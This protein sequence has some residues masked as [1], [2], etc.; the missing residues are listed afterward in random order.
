MRCIAGGHP[1]YKTGH[2]HAGYLAVAS[3]QQQPAAQREP[4]DIWTRTVVRDLICVHL[5]PRRPRWPGAKRGFPDLLRSAMLV[6][7]NYSNSLATSAT[8]Q[9]EARPSSTRRHGAT[10]VPAPQVIYYLQGCC[11]VAGNK[12]YSN[13][14]CLI[15]IRLTSHLSI[16]S[17]LS[18]LIQMRRSIFHMGV[19]PCGI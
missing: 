10:T 3:T 13:L 12:L 2:M 16:L 1:Q 17:L 9:T 7:P 6:Q 11:T 8:S 19:R 14:H 18:R 4:L 5:S 15:L